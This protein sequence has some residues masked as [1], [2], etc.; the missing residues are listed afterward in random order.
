MGGMVL[1]KLCYAVDCPGGDDRKIDG[2]LRSHDYDAVPAVCELSLEY[3]EVV[4]RLFGNKELIEGLKRQYNHGDNIKVEHTPLTFPMDGNLREWLRKET[5]IS[6]ALEF[7]RDGKVDAVYSGGNS[8]A[9]VVCARQICGL[10]D[11]IL[12]YSL[13]AHMPTGMNSNCYLNDVGANKSTSPEDLLASAVLTQIFHQLIEKDT[14]LPKIGMFDNPIAKSALPYLKELTNFAGIVKP[15]DVYEGKVKIVV[16]DGFLGNIY[17]KE[18]EALFKTIWRKVKPEGKGYLHAIWNILFSDVLKPYFTP[19]NCCL[20]RTQFRTTDTK[21]Y[22][23][24]YGKTVEETVKDVLNALDHLRMSSANIGVLSNGEEDIKGNQ[25]SHNLRKE[26]EKRGLP[27]IGNVEPKECIKGKAE[28]NGIEK[29][30]DLVATDEHTAQ[31]C[32]Q[33][34]TALEKR[35]IPFLK[36]NLTLRNMAFN[37]K[38]LKDLKELL[39]PDNYNGAPVLGVKCYENIGHGSATRPAIKAGIK[40]GIEFR[41]TGYVEKE[42]S[43]VPYIKKIIEKVK[44]KISTEKPGA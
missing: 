33:T 17:I 12:N 18:T 44:S 28:R 2:Q 16:M 9:G 37:R 30:I 13:A 31:L 29:R 1:E 11:D 26:L 32:I 24:A 21:P 22:M 6:K 4:F 7:H 40:R 39:D 19:Y 27:C 15:E 36:E 38:K 41:K 3:P 35:F 34:R 23:L 25:F 5:T 42:K 20:S 43:A 8:A 14:T 10:L